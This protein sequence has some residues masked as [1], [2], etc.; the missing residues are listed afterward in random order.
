[1]SARMEALSGAAQ[2]FED[3]SPLLEE[4]KKENVT[5][6]SYKTVVVASES[7][8]SSPSTPIGVNLPNNNWIRQEHGSKSVSLGNIIEAYGKAGGSSRIKEFAYSEEEAELSIKY[9]QI[10]DNLH[11]A[12]HEVVGHAS[13]QI[14]EGVGTPRET[15][16]S[17]AST[18]E[19]GRADLFGLYYLYSTKLEELGLVDDWKKVGMTAYNDYIRNGLMT[20]LVRINLG[21]DIEQAHMRNRQWVSSW[22]YEHGKKDNVI[23]KIEKDGK[24]YF[25]IQDYDKLRELFGELLRETQRMTSEGDFEAAKNLVENYGVKVNQDIHKEVLERNAKFN[26]APY[27]GFINPKIQPITNDSGEITGFELIQPKDF[28]EQ[29]LEYAKNYSNLPLVN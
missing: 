25:V 20:Q 2:W 22:V 24:T 23:E 27:S 17:Y 5:G 21:D 19:E 9:G 26:T 29:M 7:G 12:L 1:M 16:R 3:N 4:H 6:V 11:T 13:G 10:A 15:L 8:D 18:I 28:A 14:N